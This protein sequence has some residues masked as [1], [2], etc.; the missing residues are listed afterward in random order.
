[1]STDPKNNWVNFPN[2]YPQKAKIGSHSLGQDRT[3]Q[4]IKKP[5]NIEFKG[6][7]RFRWITSE[8]ILVE[9]AGVEPASASTTLE[10]T[11]C[12]DIVY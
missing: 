5:L 9:V 11:T 10:N 7:F 4:P 8:R 2:N 12:L 3:I 1:M 6:F